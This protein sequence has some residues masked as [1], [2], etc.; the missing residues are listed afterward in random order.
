MSHYEDDALCA[1]PLNHVLA[2]YLNNQQAEALARLK[3]IA[4]RFAVAIKMLLAK[5]PKQPP[6]DKY[7]IKIGGKPEAWF[8]RDDTLELW[9]QQGALE[10]LKESVKG[11]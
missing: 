8:Y 6:A 1:V 3:T 4:S 5:S 10:W 9:Q 2:L 7:G 11:L